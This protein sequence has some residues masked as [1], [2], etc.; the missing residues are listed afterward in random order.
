M[1]HADEFP[2]SAENTHMKHSSPLWARIVLCL[3]FINLLAGF[4][5]AADIEPPRVQLTD[6]MGVNMANGQV[7]HSVPTVSIGGAMGLSHSISVNANEFNFLGYRGYNDKYFAQARNVN[8]SN[9]VG[10]LP[11]NVLRVYDPTDTVDFA[12]VVNGIIQQDGHGITSGYSYQSIGDERQILEVNGTYLDWTKPD[13]TIVKFLRPV[14][15]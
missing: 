7:T 13:G 3:F 12:V 1:Q 5:H 9:A 15:P 11:R 14:S 10:F 4:S 8:L 6:K 2:L